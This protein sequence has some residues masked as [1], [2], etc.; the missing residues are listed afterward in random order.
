MP[1]LRQ[2]VDHFCK[3]SGAKVDVS[4][5]LRVQVKDLK[6]QLKKAKDEHKKHMKEMKKTAKAKAE[7]KAKT[8]KAPKKPR[9]PK[10]APA[11]MQAEPM[12]PA[13]T[14]S[15]NLE[16]QMGPNGYAKAATVP[17]P[18]P[19]LA[20]AAPMVKGGRA[21]RRVRRRPVLRW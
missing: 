4:D 10:A 5:K 12:L 2:K 3:D 7:P 11:P 13:E 6:E 17:V 15:R 21:T 9:A 19:S 14:R 16:A 1:T 8:Q 20:P 18:A